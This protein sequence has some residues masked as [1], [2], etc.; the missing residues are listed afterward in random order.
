[1]LPDRNNNVQ[2]VLEFYDLGPVTIPNYNTTLF[3]PTQ[4]GRLRNITRYGLMFDIVAEGLESG[5]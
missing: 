3:G 4:V 5:I 2:K 1:M